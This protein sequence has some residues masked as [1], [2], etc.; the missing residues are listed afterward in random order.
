MSRVQICGFET[1]DLSETAPGG[2]TNPTVVTAP[3]RTGS[4]A[5]RC[6]PTG[7]GTSYATVAAQA[8]DGTPAASTTG[9]NLATA[10]VRFYFQYLT[11]P[12]AGSEEVFAALDTA[13]TGK[14]RVRI[15][16]SGILSLWNTTGTGQIAA[17]TTALASGKW[18]R[19]EVTVRTG[20]TATAELKLDGTVEASGSGSNTT[21]N[22]S[23][24]ALGKQADRN[25]N[26]VDVYY[27]DVAVDNAGYPGVGEVH[28]LTPT[29]EGTDTAWA[30]G[31]GTSKVAACTELPT[32]GSATTIQTSTNAAAETLSGMS[33]AA[34]QGAIAAVKPVAS[35]SKGV[36]TTCTMK[37]PR[38]RSGAAGTTITD[39]AASAT[40]ASSS[41]FFQTQAA[42]YA[43]DPADSTAWTATR[44]G[45]LQVGV[46]DTTSQAR[47]V[48]CSWLG[49]MVESAGA[50]AGP[51]TAYPASLLM[52][53]GC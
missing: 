25:G 13:G 12:A 26:T 35:I 39:M 51:A 43:T 38:I 48:L 41:P 34:I 37:A 30:L 27:D 42:L 11:L 36:S 3:V 2:T 7:T 16:S 47:Q 40:V 5:L 24:F 23:T 4:Y 10:Y 32:D 46:V 21:A 22:C 9:F 15:D 31:A 20:A 44:L 18:Y 33:T 17:G 53:M 14:V 52:C 49:V 19:V 45:L 1:A 28:L 29:T 8:T 6:N 50:P